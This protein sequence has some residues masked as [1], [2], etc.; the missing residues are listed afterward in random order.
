MN[1]DEFYA[2]AA[3]TNM[4]CHVEISSALDGLINDPS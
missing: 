4:H 1:F 2:P 3:T